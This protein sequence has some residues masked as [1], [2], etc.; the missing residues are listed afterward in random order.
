MPNKLD[1]LAIGNAI[2]DL[3]TRV[4][5]AFL[6]RH[7][8]VKNSMNLIDLNQATRLYEDLGPAVEVSGGSAANTAAGVAAL[9]GSAAFIGKVADDQ[10]GEIFGHDIRSTGVEFTTRPDLSGATTAHSFILI[11]PDAHRTMNTY[12]GASQNLGPDDVSEDLVGRARITYLEG[13][14]WDPPKAKEAFLKAMKIAHRE[15][16]RVALTLSD[17]FCVDRYRDEFL[18]LVKDHVDILFANEDEIV[19][20][21]QTVDFASALGH[22]ETHAEIV[23]LTRSEA[24]SLI[25]AGGDRIAVPAEKAVVE[26][27]TGA[28]DLYASGFLAGF[29]RGLDLAVCGRMGSLS[30]SEIISHVGAR[31]KANLRAFVD[32]H[33]KD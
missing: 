26:D 4:D 22:V 14:L 27:T 21:Y 28:G 17:S 23:V 3:L 18:N 30:A 6:E 20:L 31:P 5:D 12:L 32:Q 29:S 15:G 10:I 11:T 1:V 24:G 25:L 9:G 19:S 33:L 16:N 13:Y 2:V 8:L 7:G